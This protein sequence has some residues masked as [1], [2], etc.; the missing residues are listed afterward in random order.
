LFQ[1]LSLQA[2][3]P[4]AVIARTSLLF[5]GQ[6]SKDSEGNDLVDRQRKRYSRELNDCFKDLIVEIKLPISSEPGFFTWSVLNPMKLMQ[7]FVQKNK[8]YRSLVD[9]AAS[10]HRPDPSNRWN[11]IMYNDEVAAGNI[12][13]ADNKR[14]ATCFYFAFKEYGLSLRSENSWLCTAVIPHDKVKLCIGGLSC[15][16][17]HLVR[18]FL[19]E[20]CD[21]FLNGFTVGV[22]RP[23]MIFSNISNILGDEA[24]LKASFASK[25]ASGLKPCLLCKNLV[26]KGSLQLHDPSRYLVSIGASLELCD[27]ASDEE[28]WAIAD[29]LR[30]AAAIH[31]RSEMD[32][33]EKA[34]GLNHC[35]SGILCC[36]I[37]SC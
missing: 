28:I 37:L 20:E 6:G 10:A 36:L 5:S 23:F 9:Q 27:Q 32:Q 1:R 16:L 31:S 22:D 19:S 11:L 35:E 25:G 13:K 17:K 24:A 34:T 3:V 26:M 2:G 12:L 21:S 7:L 14:K 29:R 33:L 18:L 4:H 8:Y 30:T 15:V